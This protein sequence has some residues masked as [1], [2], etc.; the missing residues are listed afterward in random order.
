MSE[1]PTIIDVARQAGVSKSTVSRVL[2]GDGPVS[3]Q[4]QD[5]VWQAVAHLGY[6]QNTVASSL[7]TDRTWLVMLITPE[8]T[9]PFWAAVARGVQDTIEAAGYSVV[10]A[11]SEW[12]AG[13]ERRFLKTARRNR[14]DA[15][16]INPTIVT[17]AELLATGVPT[18]LL[19]MRSDLQ[20]FDN[21]GSDTYGGVQLALNHLYALGHRRI[22]FIRGQHKS[23]RGLARQQAYQDFLQQQ[24][25]PHDPELVVEAPYELERGYQAAG[26]LLG[27]SMPPTAIFAAN[28]LLAIGAMHAAHERG[29]AIPSQL[30]IIGMDDIEAAAMTLP[31]LTTIAK[32]K[33]EI[34][35]QAVTLLLER[36][37]GHTPSQP[38]RVF[39][40]CH[41]VVR[42]S[43]ASPSAHA[44][45]LIPNS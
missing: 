40:P 10:I 37:A 4:S 19:G 23:G 35:R 12:D 1:R 20:G 15:L 39:L 13:R 28:D 21:V 42:G 29:F 44:Q 16:L 14:F 33:A 30:S 2:Q 24:S 36:L 11:N 32:P 3:R 26:L 9:N 22:G 25:L 43:T 8:L 27:R 34:G 38:R 45:S 17:N 31:G 41:L 5:A 18:V 6:E 7:R